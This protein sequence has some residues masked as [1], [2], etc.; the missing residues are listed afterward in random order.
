MKIKRFKNNKQYFNYLK[1][2]KKLI[3]IIKV[4]IINNFIYIYYELI[5]N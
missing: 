1:K 5:Y 4:N 2:N 3:N